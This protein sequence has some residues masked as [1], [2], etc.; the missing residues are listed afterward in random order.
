MKEQRLWDL[1]MFKGGNTN[2]GSCQYTEAGSPV[3]NIEAVE[4]SNTN[5]DDLPSGTRAVDMCKNAA[6][7]LSLTWDDN[8]N[9]VDK[10]PATTKYIK[11]CQYIKGIGDENPQIYYNKNGENLGSEAAILNTTDIVEGFGYSIDRH[12]HIPSQDDP[13]L[14]AQHY[15]VYRLVRSADYG[16]WIGNGMG[17]GG[18]ANTNTRNWRDHGYRGAPA[19]LDGIWSNDEM[20]GP[21]GDCGCLKTMI[22][23][24]K[25]KII[26]NG[27]H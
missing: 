18:T 14:D 20:C 17:E 21:D 2:T 23:N 22:V 26:I 3:A 12:L 27:Q 11:G 16:G 10:N 7:S 5:K 8:V 1:N 19:T 13:E 9:I 15:D 6:L 25:E 4:V 24:L